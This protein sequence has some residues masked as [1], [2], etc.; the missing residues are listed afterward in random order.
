MAQVF[1]YF[2]DLEEQEFN[3]STNAMLNTL[4]YYVQ[5]AQLSELQYEILC[6]KIKKQTNQ[7]IQQYINKK[8][9]K[10]YTVNYISTIFRQKIIPSIIEGIKYHMNIVENLFFEEE[11]KK[12]IRCGRV[13][14][15]HP[16]NFVRKARSQ[17]GFNNKCK[18]CEKKERKL[19]GEKNGK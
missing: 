16:Y 1:L 9:D 7:Q 11:F 15:I 10:S 18:C 3:K 5:F 19:R 4:K 6:L 14:L 2:E 17:D 8:Y 12:C 13:L